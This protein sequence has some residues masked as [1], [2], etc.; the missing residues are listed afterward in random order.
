MKVP[1]ERFGFGEMGFRILLDGL[2]MVNLGDTILHHHHWSQ[3]DPADI[4]M[5]P[6][7]GKIPGN[8]MDETDALTAV[9]IFNPKMVIPTHY[10]CAALFSKCYNPADDEGFKKEVEALGHQCNIISSGH[11]IEIP[12]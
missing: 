1:S 10:N 12:D 5:I 3:L 11:S 2:A 4:L 9:R 7:G 6:I 8:T